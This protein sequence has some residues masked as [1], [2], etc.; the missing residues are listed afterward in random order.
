MCYHPRIGYF[1][2]PRHWIELLDLWNRQPGNIDDVPCKATAIVILNKLIDLKLARDAD[3]P[4]MRKRKRKLPSIANN[5]TAPLDAEVYPTYRCNNNCRF[6]SSKNR[7][8]N[9][10]GRLDLRYEYLDVIA[11]RLDE[12]G[13]FNVGIVGG[14]PFLYS[15]L[16]DL[17][18]ALIRRGVH[19]HLTTNGS[20]TADRI[21]GICREGVHIAVS[22]HGVGHQEHERVTGRSGSFLQ[23][24]Q[25]VSFLARRGIPFRIISVVENPLLSKIKM[26]AKY[27]ADL[28][29]AEVTFCRVTRIGK[30]R[31][32]EARQW[33]S[34]AIA[35][36]ET[37]FDH[38]TRQCR[39]NMRAGLPFRLSS[40][41]HGQ[42]APPYI[43]TGGRCD[44]GVRGLY[45][46][47]S[48][49]LYPCDLLAS[50]EYRLGNILGDEWP[51]LL[52]SSR[53]LSML[54]TLQSPES[55]K[56][57][58]FFQACR[59]GCPGLRAEFDGNLTLPMLHCPFSNGLELS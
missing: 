28:G 30:A 50:K 20:S 26:M 7:S 8:I 4:I 2:V 47:P 17:V 38:N 16:E 44:A 1:I 53:V 51:N 22:I 35:Q 19:V 58:D 11:E 39:F 9:E 33:D 48:G 18:D 56:S 21:A 49:D 54:R 45:I 40:P 43:K 55:C 13:V 25:T 36:F 6:C 32:Y 59:G 14:E 12:A 42:T 15:H 31:R 27:W 37:L 52:A 34:R 5:I 24:I 29:A 10:Y 3:A 57:C 23:A 46:D 41:P